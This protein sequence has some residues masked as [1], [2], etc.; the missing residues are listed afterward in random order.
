MHSNEY[1]NFIVVVEFF[2]MSMSM[3]MSMSTS[4]STSMS[5]EYN[6]SGLGLKYTCRSSFAKIANDVPSL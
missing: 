3:S 5:I 4:M 2:F 6:D 1:S